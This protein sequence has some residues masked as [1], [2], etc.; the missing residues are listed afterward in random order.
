MA[1]PALARDVQ[2]WGLDAL[3]VPV[4]EM[5]FG[6]V[7]EMDIGQVRDALQKF[8]YELSFLEEEVDLG[9]SLT[10]YCSLDNPRAAE[11]EEANRRKEAIAQ[12]GGTYDLLVRRFTGL[13]ESDID[14]RA[15]DLRARQAFGSAVISG[16]VF[17]DTKRGTNTA[18]KEWSATVDGVG[19]FSLKDI[20]PLL[21]T[22]LDR[23]TRKAIYL[24][25]R[26][27]ESV[28]EKL[29]TQ[30]EEVNTVIAGLAPQFG[31]AVT[32]PFELK[33]HEYETPVPGEVIALFTRFVEQTKGIYDTLFAEL[34]TCEEIQPWD[35]SFLLVQKDPFA[36]LDVPQDP[37]V[38]LGK[39]T[40]FLK[41]LG[42]DHTLIDELYALDNPNVHID[43]EAREGKLPAAMTCSLGPF[44]KGKG[45]LY[46]EPTVFSGNARK[47]WGVFPHELGHG[48]H[49]HFT[50][51]VTDKGAVFFWE[52]TPTSETFSMFHD[53]L[54][55]GPDALERYLGT[56]PSMVDHLQKWELL[57]TLEKIYSIARISAVEHSLHTKGIDAA[58]KTFAEVENFTSPKNCQDV[59][60]SSGYAM[61]G[62][63]H[64]MPGYYCSYN[65]AEL[66]RLAIM[67]E[68][69]QRQKTP[70]FNIAKFV[71][72]EL[73]TGNVLPMSERVRRVTGV[74]DVAANAARYIKQEYGRL[75][76]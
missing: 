22:T 16:S 35:L 47:R 32:N 56:D 6:S 7:G 52:P 11:T 13:A 4:L 14:K 67:A 8:D 50:R 24:A 62:H 20:N 15:A 60:P 72:G 33:M 34:V 55:R 28:E 68:V 21:Q 25:S 63:I 75:R 17:R 39:A 10:N 31:V 58:R 38:L 66:N 43:I 27:L 74:T 69:R 76:R 46:Y 9:S 37:F 59:Q 71:S 1:Q 54:A 64:A 36:K 2:P 48:L 26:D 49:Y 40:Q 5:D 30:I 57:L 42:Y 3:D 70:G 18:F 29:G 12:P 51:R 19:A 41:D 44:S 45:I 65:L 73:M 53:G 61:V 23:D